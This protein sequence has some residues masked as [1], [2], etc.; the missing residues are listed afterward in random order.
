LDLLLFS[1]DMCFSLLFNIRHLVKKCLV[2]LHLKHILGFLIELIRFSC[3]L[4]NILDNRS[5]SPSTSKSLSNKDTRENK[6]YILEDGIALVLELE[7]R[8]RLW[9]SIHFSILP[10]TPLPTSDDMLWEE[11]IHGECLIVAGLHDGLN[12]GAPHGT[13]KWVQELQSSIMVVI[14]NMITL[15]LMLFTVTVNHWN[16]V[17]WRLKHVT[18]FDPQAYR[19]T[20]FSP[21]GAPKV[22]VNPQSKG[23]ASLTKY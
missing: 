21:Q 15:A 8:A 14:R 19:P 1:L 13:I 10:L 4:W 5:S 11:L 18:T 22:L 7:M 17:C 3:I 20:T 16:M 6:E 2:L 9:G 12:L 23:I